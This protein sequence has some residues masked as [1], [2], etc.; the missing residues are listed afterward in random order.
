MLLIHNI[1]DRDFIKRET[2]ILLNDAENFW[3]YM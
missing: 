3:N 1:F 2:K